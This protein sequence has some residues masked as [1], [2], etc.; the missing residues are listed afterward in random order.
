M[1]LNQRIKTVHS[2]KLIKTKHCH[3]AVMGYRVVLCKFVLFLIVYINGAILSNIVYCILHMAATYLPILY[4]IYNSNYKNSAFNCH[5]SSVD[6][7]CTRPMVIIF[8]STA[9]SIYYTDG[10]N[11]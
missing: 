3:T 7:L 1:V 5:D 10:Y 4:C 8:D 11:N 6:F 9:P 2:L